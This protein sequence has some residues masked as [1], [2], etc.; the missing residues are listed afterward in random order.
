MSR[1]PTS[2]GLLPKAEHTFAQIRDRD[3]ELPETISPVLPYGLGRSYG[4]SCLNDGGSLLMMRG[5]D[6]WISFDRETGLMECESGVS[7]AEILELV[8]PAGWFLPVTPG[9]RHVTVGGAIANDVHGKNHHRAG[10]FGAHVRSF[11]LVRSDGTRRIC[12]RTSH[13]QWFRATVGGLGLTGMITRATLQLKPIVSRKI[14]VEEIRMGNL[15]D[16][17]QLADESDTTHEYTVSWV[18]CLASGDEVGRGIFIRGNH[19][20]RPGPLQP[21]I[22]NAL[23]VPVHAPGWLLNKG[24]ISAFNAV[25]RNKFQGERKTME[26]DYRPFFYPLDKLDDWNRLYGKRGFFQH[27]CVLPREGDGGAIAEILDRIGKSGQASFLAVLKVFGDLPPE[28]LLSFPRPGVTLALDFPNR[29]EATLK[30]MQE[31]DEVVMKAGGALYPAKDAR[32]DGKH[33]R[34]FTPALDVFRPFMDPA[35]S[36]SF[37]RRVFPDVR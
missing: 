37:Q 27:Q 10:T 36:S 11:E 21:D 22:G 4:D 28:G 34:A 13:A 12:S 20:E 18:D 7:L 30:L 35:F 23:S 16:F 5:L 6:R 17:F 33:Y 19:S 24:S 9:T 8:V 2:W 1:A 15:K 3:H 32:M 26:E 29:G 31:L 25:Y 14:D